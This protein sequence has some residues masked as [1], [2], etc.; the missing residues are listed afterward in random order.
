MKGSSCWDRQ[1][2]TVA[3]IP[4]SHVLNVHISNPYT[5]IRVQCGVP[6]L[7]IFLI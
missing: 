3:N 4:R 7:M 5:G 1:I 2:I 6:S